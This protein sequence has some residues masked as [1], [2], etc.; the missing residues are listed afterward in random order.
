MV[1]VTQRMDGTKTRWMQVPVATGCLA[2]VF[3]VVMPAAE[4]TTAGLEFRNTAKG[5][6]FVGSEACAACHPAIY[7]SYKKTSMARSM[8]LASDMKFDFGE[9]KTTVHSEQF[10]RDYSVTKE[11]D[12]LHESESEI[13][14]SGASVLRTTQKLEFAMGS[15]VNGITFLVRSGDFLLEAPVSY[16]TKVRKWALSP[17]YDKDDQ[18]F[19]RTIPAACVAC[20]TGDPRP[21]PEIR[22]MFRN[23]PFV[24]TGIGCENCH[25][26]GQLHVAERSKGSPVKV[27]TS[28]VNPAKLA[29]R[30]ADEICMNCHQG[31]AMR[32]LQPGKEFSDYRPSLPL[33]QTVAIFAPPLQRGAPETSPLLQHHTLMRLSKCYRASAGKMG[34]Q[35]CHDPH[36]QPPAEPSVYFREK[37][38]Q[39]H[40][41]ADCKL[42]SAARAA[43]TPANDCAGCHMRKADV[44]IPHSVLTNHRIIARADEPLPDEAYQDQG[45]GLRGLVHINAIPGVKDVIPPLTAMR[46]YGEMAQSDPR[47]AAD[48]LEALDKAAQ[49]NPEDPA[50]LSGLGWREVTN[51][52][53]EAKT[54]AIEYLRQAIQKG[55]H[56]PL[57]YEKLGELLR[58]AG[59]EEEAIAVLEQGIQDNPFTKRL[60]QQLAM[61]YI[62][63]KRY[64]L[65]LSTMHREL[66]RFPDDSFVRKLIAEAEASRH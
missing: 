5:V 21:V 9:T 18:G 61:T 42:P 16:Y 48:Y 59:K 57:N 34:C 22:G 11:R 26:P 6:R 53:P 56:A 29:H 54:K 47:Y 7:R 52:S 45:A 33:D 31:T 51:R 37:C 25:G 14:A 35:T 17:G 19:S 15:G 55:S 10:P 20:H 62:A 27:D 46:A 64:P 12:G 8:S 63:V 66:E 39:C 3:C 38:L 50:V 44:T 30:L 2:V 23:P 43:R 4:R 60:Y 58:E 28:I 40:T 24:E 49:T 36:V 32:V 41:D 13:D 1:G 65:A